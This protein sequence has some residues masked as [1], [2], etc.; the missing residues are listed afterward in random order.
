M[1]FNLAVCYMAENPQLNG[2]TA[3]WYYTQ[4]ETSHEWDNKITNIK[5]KE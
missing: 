3:R 4:P 1:I 2:T 5:S